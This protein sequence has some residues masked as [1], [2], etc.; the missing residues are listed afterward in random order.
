MGEF[1]DTLD[2]L[3]PAQKVAIGLSFFMPLIKSGF[4][5]FISEQPLIKIRVYNK[6]PRKEKPRKWR[7]MLRR[8]KA[9]QI[10]TN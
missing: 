8:R 2:K 4:Q 3:T 9:Q 5:W 1:K 7:R 10:K 6:H